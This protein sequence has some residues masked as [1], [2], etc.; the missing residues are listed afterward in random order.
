MLFLGAP[1]TGKSPPLARIW[2]G[3]T[4]RSGCRY[5]REYWDL[6]NI[7]RRLTLPQLEEIA[8]GHMEREKQLLLQAN[9]VVH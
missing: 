6:H 8:V 2:R 9:R 4:P 7:D 3:S 5:G 1:S